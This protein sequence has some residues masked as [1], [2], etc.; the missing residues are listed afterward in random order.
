NVRA[1]VLDARLAPAPAG[2]AG[3]LYLGGAQVARGYA[4]RPGLTAERFVPDPFVAG[5][6]MYRTGDLARW[7]PD[8]AIE[9]LGRDDF[10]VKVRGFRI[11]LGEIEARLA[12]LDGIAGVVVLAREDAAGDRRLVAYYTG[13]RAPDAAALRRHAAQHLPEY[14]VPA[15]YVKLAALPVSPNGKLDRGALPAP[16]RDAHVSGAYDPPRG[17]IEGA[18]ARLLGEL[19][20]AEAV[21][22]DDDFFE[23]GG[24]SL[25]AVRAVSRIRAAL[26][27]DLSLRGLLDAPTVAGLAREV[28]R[29][30]TLA[31][32][33]AAAAAALP[34]LPRD[35]PLPPSPV[36]EG[37]WFQEQLHPGVYSEL[38]AIRTAGPLDP[39]RLR[40]CLAAIVRRHEAL[41]SVLVARDGAPQVHLLEALPEPLAVAP[42]TDEAGL[43]E[44]ARR[45]ARRPF[46]LARGPLT[47][48]V[49]V[50]LGPEQH[51]LL[52][53]HHHLVSDG[54]SQAVLLAELA[55]HY[56]ADA[57]RRAPRLPPLAAQYADHAAWQRARLTEA[58]RDELLGHW[59]RALAGLP[60]ALELPADLPRPP[61]PSYRGARHGFAIPAPL[62]GEL[63]RLGRRHGATPFM[64]LLALF[65]A[66]LARYT[67]RRDVVVGTPASTRDR[68]EVEPLIGLF[69]NTVP[70]RLELPR[71]T[72][73]AELL[74]RSRRAVTGALAHRELPFPDLVAG[75][76][77]ARDPGRHPIVQVMFGLE[78]ALPPVRAAE[79]E[80]TAVELDPGVARFD[81]S[82]LLC[83]HAGGELTGALEYAVDLFAPATIAQLAHHYVALAAEACRRPDAPVA[84]LALPDLDDLDDRLAPTARAARA[85]APARRA[86]PRSV[87]EQIERQMQREP[88]RIAIAGDGDGAALR[89]GE[90]DRR[91]AL[92]GRAL[93]ARGLGPDRRVAIVSERSPA[94][95][96]AMLATLRAGGA[97]APIDPRLPR[98]RMAA[99]LRQLDPV[100]VLCPD[101]LRGAL[102]VDG[103]P[104]LGLDDEPAWR[105]A[106][107]AATAAPPAP[108]P[109][110]ALAYVIYTSGSTGV[111]RGV[112]IPR[113]GLD[114]QLG[115]MQEEYRL[116]PD[117]RFL[118][119]A[120]LMFDFSVIEVFWPL[121]VGA[122]VVLPRPRGEL[123]PAYLAALARRHGATAVHFVPSL[124]RVLVD[125]AAPASWDG[126]RLLFCGGEALAPDLVRR[127]GAVFPRAELHNQYGPTEA[128]INATYCRVDGHPP[129]VPIGR[130]VPDLSAFVVDDDLAPVPRGA[131]GELVLAGVQLARGYLGCPA[132]T[133]ARFVPSPFAAVPGERL[134]RTGDLARVRPDGALEYVGRSDFQVKV[135]GFR[136]ELG[137]VEAALG[138]HPAVQRAVCVAS[139]PP[140]GDDR[141]RLVGYVEWRG[142]PA[143]PAELARF[144]GERLPDYMIPSAYVAVER[145]PLTPTGKLDRAA[146][147]APSR[148]APGPAAPLSPSEQRVAAVWSEL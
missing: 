48:F 45:E 54:I 66:L 23:L 13:A 47:R 2:V 145:W 60:P 114:A 133:A 137:D 26:G 92:L 83:E 40:R 126:I 141:A 109:P 139:R 75:L 5:A 21:G 17:E 18:L 39:D 61:V 64:T 135:R 43:A 108:A 100:A 72:T 103:P 131:I 128:T 88:D 9:F 98:A 50:P 52:W 112:M 38:S 129:V 121:L 142:A 115:W 37:L 143:P 69:V 74:R 63:R 138:A 29:A 94:A 20:G 140:G 110:D 123:E 33:A 89:Y 55:E 113:R 146:L 19:L 111:P 42:P 85:P 107:A 67:G 34:R 120:S 86:P 76:A 96:A 51:A 53:H 124:L 82:M 99:M 122:Q 134:Y 14:M 125:E 11:E 62:A 77:P 27:V 44:V 81:L 91:S 59:R 105:A 68:D 127:C 90:L 10:Q 106:A 101:E 93:A 41:R 30:P 16:A 56:A 147:P 97:Y 104:I 22:R 7:L 25:L 132:E 87:V 12:E 31:A 80:L 78:V 71:D 144:L 118:Q 136:V 36:Q 57:E 8:G 119:L 1:Y 58:R 70:V 73:V 116:T 95:L 102:P 148:E 3:E 24:H 84:R 32:A 28:A 4:G 6:R 117:D 79:L 49:L 15:A 35:R 130:P 65:E 46:D